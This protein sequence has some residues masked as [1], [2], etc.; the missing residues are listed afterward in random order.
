[1]TVKPNEVEIA[2]Q[3]LN[4]DEERPLQK[5]EVWTIK[6]AVDRAIFHRFIQDPIT[7]KWSKPLHETK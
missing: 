5:G 1:M 6:W 7:K 4:R 2:L 3:I